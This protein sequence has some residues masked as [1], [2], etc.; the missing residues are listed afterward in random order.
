MQTFLEFQTALWLA[1]FMNLYIK[2]GWLRSVAKEHNSRYVDSWPLEEI[3]IVVTEFLYEVKH[4]PKYLK[5]VR[6]LKSYN[7]IH[8]IWT[9]LVRK[10]NSKFLRAKDYYKKQYIF[11]E[12]AFIT[13]AELHG[14]SCLGRVASSIYFC[15]DIC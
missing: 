6:F 9:R 7:K 13:F 5:K 11:W 3:L 2:S 8:Y 14:H 12:V 10:L 4:P 15:M 1:R